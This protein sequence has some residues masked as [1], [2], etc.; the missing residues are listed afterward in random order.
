MKKFILGIFVFVL[1]LNGWAV[2]AETDKTVKKQKVYDPFKSEDTLNNMDSEFR[3]FDKKNP[4]N[5]STLQ[6]FKNNRR[7]SGSNL[8]K[9]KISEKPKLYKKVKLVLSDKRK[10]IGQ[11]PFL[12]DSIKI[13]FKKND[14]SFIKEISRKAIKKIVFKKWVCAKVVK[15]N[16]LDTD[17]EIFKYY[18]M[19][20]Q[21][22]IVLKN[23]AT[24]SGKINPFELLSFIIDNENGQSSYV[25]FF[26]D[27]W[28]PESK[29]E[30]KKLI[31]TEEEDKI[32]GKSK[33]INFI[34]EKAAK[35]DFKYYDKNIPRGVVTELSVLEEGK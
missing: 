22:N 23:N 6:I 9:P 4:A 17:Y 35:K 19:P 34:W 28:V 21:A 32:K 3:A 2:L 26:T 31:V 20:I 5:R 13:K 1:Y 16:Y 27:S 7:S 29:N 30:L 8:I 14:I 18:F 24:L 11:T 15:S 12:G 25:S 10:I 33:K